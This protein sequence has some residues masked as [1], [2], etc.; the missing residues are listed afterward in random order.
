VKGRWIGW[1]GNQEAALER[2]RFYAVIA[3]FR[4]LGFRTVDPERL[5]HLRSDL[6]LQ[7]GMRLEAILAHHRL[8]LAALLPGPIT[9][10]SRPL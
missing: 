7:F 6:E 8:W 1:F 2:A 5:H 9:I 4:I 3:R 10:E